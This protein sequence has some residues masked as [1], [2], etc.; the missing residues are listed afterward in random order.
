MACSTEYDINTLIRDVSVM[1]S[2]GDGHA[3][4]RPS[5]RTHIVASACQKLYHPMLSIDQPFKA[6]QEQH[7]HLTGARPES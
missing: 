2:T 3:E 6:R 4:L 5:E 7:R 1:T